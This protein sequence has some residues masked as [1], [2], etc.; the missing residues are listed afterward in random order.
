M[1][2]KQQLV[3]ARESLPGDGAEQKVLELEAQAAEYRRQMGEQA[4]DIAKMAARDN[5][6]GLTKLSSS[7]SSHQQQVDEFTAHIN[8]KKICFALIGMTPDCISRSSKN[9]Q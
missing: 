2:L 3:A 9:I 1:S 4:A 7:S 5:F 6:T 8:V